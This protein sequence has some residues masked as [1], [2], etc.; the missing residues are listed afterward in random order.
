MTTITMPRFTAEDADRAYDEWGVNCGPGAIAAICG[1]T[2][3]ELR[4]HMG[5]FE[6][7]HYTNPTLMWQVLD[8][9]GARWRLVKPPRTWPEYGLARV[10]WEGP[11]TAPGVPARAAYRHTH[12]VGAA[13][14][15]VKGVGIF[16]INAIGNGSGWCALEDWTGTLVPWILDECVPHASGGW[17]L[18]HVVEVI[19]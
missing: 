12:W 2:L 5:D 16:D 3:D 4:P 18:T 6:R 19:R 8:S 10:Q 1:M 9:I 11:W 17:H 7:K 15:P 13:R 14:D